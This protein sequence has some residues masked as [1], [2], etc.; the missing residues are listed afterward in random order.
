MKTKIVYS[1]VS[2]ENDIYLEQALVSIY[3]LKLYNPNAIV[4]LIIDEATNTSIQG[5]RSE[6]LKYIDQKIVITA[7]ATY[8]KVQISR[9]LKTTLRQHIKGD[10]LFVDSDTII[11][12]TL[13]DIDYFKGDIGAVSDFHVSLKQHYG[14]KG[15]QHKAQILNWQIDDKSPYYNSGVIYVRDNANTANF[16]KQWNNEWKNYLEKGFHEDQPSFN[17]TNFQ[18]GNIIQPLDGIWNCQ[19]L[20]NGIPFLH[21]AKIIH[22]FGSW[23]SSGFSPNAYKFSQKELYYKIKETGYLTQDIISSNPQLSS[24]ASFLRLN[25]LSSLN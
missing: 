6:I 8:N 3:S 7:P 19:I 12:D 2:N 24:S 21:Q 14:F 20:W 17:K 16:F 4:I 13:S 15:I 1:V 9:Y 22:F 25:V 18:L 5:K 10:F 23:K 11:V